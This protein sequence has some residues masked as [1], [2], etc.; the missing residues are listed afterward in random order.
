MNNSNIIEQND[1]HKNNSSLKVRTNQTNDNDNNK[2]KNQF[3]NTSFEPKL[4]P[5]KNC[6]SLYSIQDTHKSERDKK[7]EQ[8]KKSEPDKKNDT[9][10]IEEKII[11]QRKEQAE[12]DNKRTYKVQVESI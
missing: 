7:Q 11:A 4:I 9:Q 12:F 5:I 1:M 6:Q 3:S 2:N 8:H 10:T